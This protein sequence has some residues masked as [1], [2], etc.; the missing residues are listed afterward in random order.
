MSS[1]EGRLSGILV[2][3]E[4]AQLLVKRS[5]TWR[6][7]IYHQSHTTS[8]A[9]ESTSAGSRGARGDGATTYVFDEASEDPY[10]HAITAGRRSQSPRARAPMAVTRAFGHPR[11]SMEIVSSASMHPIGVAL[12]DGYYILRVELRHPGAAVWMGPLLD[13]PRCAFNP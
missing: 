6:A 10:W 7:R 3:I 4:A 1:D 5:S 2:R 9:S 12:R 13:V 11:A 8:C